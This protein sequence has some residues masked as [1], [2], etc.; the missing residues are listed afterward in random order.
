[1]VTRFDRVVTQC[2][3]CKETLAVDCSPDAM[4]DK[5]MARRVPK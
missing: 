2:D 3:N 1:M 4:L 5:V